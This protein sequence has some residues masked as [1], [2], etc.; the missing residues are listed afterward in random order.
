MSFPCS[1]GEVC[2][3]AVDLRIS[4]YIETNCTFGYHFMSRHNAKSD[5]E[6]FRAFPPEES[7]D[8]VLPWQPPRTAALHWQLTNTLPVIFLKG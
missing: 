2:Y 6:I 7:R 5:A 8:W 4:A 1:L 3:T